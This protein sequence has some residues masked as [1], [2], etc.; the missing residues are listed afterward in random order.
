M[1]FLLLFIIL[2][3]GFL[4][5]QDWQFKRESEGIKVWT[6]ER[7]NSNFKLFKAQGNIEATLDQMERV[8]LDIEKMHLWYDHIAE[9][10]V[11]KQISDREGIISVEIDLPWPF[12]D[13]F[14]V[15]RA[16]MKKTETT[17]S[18][19]T[20]HEKNIDIEHDGYVWVDDIGS[21]WN[22]TK[23]SPTTLTIEHIGYLDPA[24][25]IPAWLASIGFEKGP[26]KTMTSLRE[27]VK[28]Y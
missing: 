28:T 24:G 20:S 21:Q 4:Q 10:K 12:T 9:N 11:L 3:S 25:T 18:I 8:F 27:F 2:K 1:K 5:A 15:L 14:S 23:T 13:R 22:I 19:T 26:I 6:A 17:L 16:T 7:A